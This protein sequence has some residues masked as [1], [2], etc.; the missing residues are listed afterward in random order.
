MF[1]SGASIP[2]IV[3]VGVFASGV[4]CVGIIFA[5]CAWRSSQ[6]MALK[7]DM[8]ERGFTAEEIV[9]VMSAQRTTE[10]QVPV[11]LSVASTNKIGDTASASQV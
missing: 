7:R 11:P 3:I 1:L 8:I 2:V 9:A 4:L 5:Y 6:E 10:G